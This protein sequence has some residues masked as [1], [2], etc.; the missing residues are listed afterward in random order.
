MKQLALFLFCALIA[1]SCDE[2][3][4]LAEPEVI[5]FRSVKVRWTGDYQVDGCG[6]FVEIDSIRHKPF[7]EDYFSDDFQILNDTI[8]EMKYLDLNKEITSQCG[9]GF[10]FKIRGIEILDIK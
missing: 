6:F 8:V 2:E 3:S 5:D 4:E 7:N 10:P 9:E 1:L